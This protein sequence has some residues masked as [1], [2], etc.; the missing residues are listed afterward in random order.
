MELTQTQW[1]EIAKMD[2]TNEGHALA[3]VELYNGTFHFNTQVGWL[4]WCGTHWIQAGA[5]SAVKRAMLNTLAVRR[6]AC[7]TFDLDEK[8]YKRCKGEMREVRDSLSLVQS[9]PSVSLEF[10]KFDNSVGVL[11]CKNGVVHLK[12]GKVEAHH[13]RQKNTYCLDY[14]YD[15]SANSQLWQEFL[16]GVGLSDEVQAFLQK[17]VGYSLTGETSEEVMFY[18]YG[19]PRSGK[20][21]FTEMLALMLGELGSGVNFRSFT[22]DRHGD[23]SN[24]DMAPLK[25]KRF[26]T[27]SESSR[28]K[29]LNTAVIKQITGGDEIYCSFKRKDHFSYRPLFVLWLTSNWPINA[30]VDDDAAWGR[31]MA[32]FFP[33]SFLGNEDKTLK[34][35]LKQQANIEGVLAWA[36]AGAMAWYA[37]LP[38]GLKPPKSVIETRD[39]HRAE[40]DTVGKFL[41]ECCVVNADIHCQGHFLYNS[42][43]DWCARDEGQTPKIRKTFTQSLEQHGILS[44]T[45]REVGKVTRVYTGVG[46]R[47]IE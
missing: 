8:M 22:S 23:T 35:R 7:A 15:P 11:N 26:L 27:A 43:T 24:F 1:Q 9:M 17:A 42:Y 30:D 46:L 19:K 41:D 40:L 2:Y 29:Q 31:L 4:K 38:N 14:N 39:S 37:S 16:N 28:F 45:K 21:T 34:I 36:V 5:D 18:L 12:T 47:A 10:D 20:G 25:N 6:Q 44:V 33:N 32:I 13:P 3:F